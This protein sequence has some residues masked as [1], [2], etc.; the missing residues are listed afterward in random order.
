MLVD[1]GG[2]PVFGKR[3]TRPPIDIG[4]EVISPYLFSRGIRTVDIIVAT[5]PTKTT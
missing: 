4:E 1:A 2:F 3:P 5:T